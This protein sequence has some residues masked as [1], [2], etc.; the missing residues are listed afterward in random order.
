MTSLK[1]GGKMCLMEK[2]KKIIPIGA[3]V[4]DYFDIKDNIIGS[5]HIRGE[6]NK[7]NAI[8]YQLVG[9]NENG[10]SC[11]C[12][13]VVDRGS[14][15]PNLIET[16]A[17]KTKLI[18][19]MSFFDEEINEVEFKIK[20]AE[21][22]LESGSYNPYINKSLFKWDGNSYEFI[23]K[24][25]KDNKKS[26]YEN[27]Y[28]AWT[29]DKHQINKFTNLHNNKDGLEF[30]VKYTDCEDKKGEFLFNPVEKEDLNLFE[31]YKRQYIKIHKM[32]YLL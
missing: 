26:T 27:F 18:M 11:E 6:I 8:G 19:A 2:T 7:P 4:Q 5:V 12:S 13:I 9:N 24:R 31:K 32:D 10:L 1:S 3:G 30:Y 28:I 25:K 22:F 21:I 23:K 29:F 16:N 20:K 15:L 17:S 14:Y